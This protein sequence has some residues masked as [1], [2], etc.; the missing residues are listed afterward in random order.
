MLHFFYGRCQT[1]LDI[2]DTVLRF[3]CDGRHVHIPTGDRLR[4]TMFSDPAYG[5]LKEIVVISDRDGTLTCTTFPHDTPVDLPVPAGLVPP[6]RSRP[7]LAVGPVDEIIARIHDQ[8]QFIGGRL[9]D[10]WPEQ[11]MV[12]RFLDPNAKV[13]EIGANIGRNTL[14]IASLLTD[15]ANLVTM[16]CDP[17]AVEILRC[18]RRA[19]G[20]AFRIEPS[21]L[22]CRPLIQRGWETVPADE[23]RPGWKPVSTITFKDLVAKYGTAFDTLV[24]DCEGALFYILQDDPSILDGIRT[25]I[26]EADYLNVEHKLSVESVFARQGLSQIHSEP[27]VVDWQHPFPDEVAASFFEVWTRTTRD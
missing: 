13:L 18:N 8:L 11:T 23:V 14:T 4:A 20:F 27:L 10:E 26:L 3:C 5:H 1:Y 21:A 12:V 15:S 25:V 9:T 6:A 24:A 7:V 16:E 2:T 17:A 22:S 19:N